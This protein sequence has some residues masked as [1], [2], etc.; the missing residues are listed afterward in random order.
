MNMM[1]QRLFGKEEQCPPG[2]TTVS[3]IFQF[4]QGEQGGFVQSEAT[5]LIIGQGLGVMLAF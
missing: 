2:G 1:A 5:G 4:F 3:Q